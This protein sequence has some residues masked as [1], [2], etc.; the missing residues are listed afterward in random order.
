M[1]ALKLVVGLIGVF[2]LFLAGIAY[3]V[4][5]P[6]GW[7]NYRVALWTI[8]LPY[9]GAVGV[10]KG[11]YDQLARNERAASAAAKVV[12]TGYIASQGAVNRRIS[13]QLGDALQN[14]RVVHDTQVKEITR[15]VTPDIDRRYPL[16]W[17]FVLMR[18][19]IRAGAPSPEA[20][21]LSAPAGTGNGDAS[22][23]ALS[24]ELAV[25]ADNDG[26]DRVCRAELSAWQD[27]YPKQ[28]AAWD[29]MRAQLESAEARALSGP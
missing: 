11:R 29:A 3:V 15:Y 23:Y 16:P 19:A 2:W 26:A 24:D 21:G 10:W 22:P 27:W 4:Y 28:K 6:A 18:D 8:H 7:P 9:A 25:S 13:A 20:A 5:V 12:F 1:A 14:V 17:G